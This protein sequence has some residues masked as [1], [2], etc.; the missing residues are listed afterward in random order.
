MRPASYNE[1]V[2]S[3]CGRRSSLVMKPVYVP[4][5]REIIINCFPD[6]PEISWVDDFCKKILTQV[7]SG[8]FFFHPII[9]KPS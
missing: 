3:T 1:R 2:L 4:S 5:H 6:Y 9:T 8:Y 7:D